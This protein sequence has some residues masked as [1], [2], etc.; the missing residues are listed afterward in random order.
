MELCTPSLTHNCTH[1]YT[2]NVALFI[3]YREMV[4][5]LRDPPYIHHSG[6]CILVKVHAHFAF[7]FFSSD[8]CMLMLII[9]TTLS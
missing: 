3:G 6:V 1:M 9:I 7:H 8:V 4:S 5:L 2:K